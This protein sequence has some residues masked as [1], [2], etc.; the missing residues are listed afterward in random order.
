MELQVPEMIFTPSLDL[1]TSDGFYDLIEGLVND[2]YSQASKINRLA[3]HNGQDHYQHDMEETDELSEMRN[4][5][6]E[7][8]QN[9]MN[10]ACDYRNSFDNYAYLWV[11]L[12]YSQTCDVIFY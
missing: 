4:E 3:T 9:I 11:R 10:Q 5:L 6:M 1:G 12:K 8:V 7:R 2:I